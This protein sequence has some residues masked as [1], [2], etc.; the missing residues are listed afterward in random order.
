MAG[1]ADL[2]E[3]REVHHAHALLRRRPEQFSSAHSATQ[4]H[5]ALCKGYASVY[6]RTCGAD[7]SSAPPADRTASWPLLAFFSTRTWIPALPAPPATV[8]GIDEKSTQVITRRTRRK[9]RRRAEEGRRDARGGAGPRRMA[10]L[11]SS[12]SSFP[13]QLLQYSTVTARSPPPTA[14]GGDAIPERGLDG[15]CRGWTRQTQ[16]ATRKAADYRYRSKLR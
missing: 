4:W 6:C 8:A 1:P 11:T 3:G 10:A 15:I 9:G 2:L 14:G 7:Q 13:A 5:R 16:D 12:N